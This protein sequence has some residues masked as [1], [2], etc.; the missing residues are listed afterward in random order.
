MMNGERCVDFYPLVTLKKR[1]EGKRRAEIM[2]AVICRL[3]R[4]WGWRGRSL[5]GNNYG[6]SKCGAEAAV[7]AEGK[8]RVDGK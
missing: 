5:K 1:R 4:F 2:P 7:D 3:M 8:T 6:L